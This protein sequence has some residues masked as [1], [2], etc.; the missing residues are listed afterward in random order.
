MKIFISWSGE[1]SHKIA[2]ILDQWIPCI[3][4]SVETFFSTE[5][6]EKGDNWD[7][8]ISERLSECNHGIICLTP[9]NLNAP[10]INFEA[11]AIAKTF[12]SKVTALMININPS[13]IKGPL[14]RYQATRLEKNDFYQLIFSINKELEKPLE[15][16]HLKN[17]FDSIW[18][19]LE[20][21]INNAI[22]DFS[23]KN[24]SVNNPVLN[25]NNPLE[26]ILQLL[27]I[28]NTMLSNPEKLIPIE[29]LQEHL[30]VEKKTFKS[31]AYLANKSKRMDDLISRYFAQIE[32]KL[33]ESAINFEILL[34]QL[35]FQFLFNIFVTY[36]L[37][38]DR[39]NLFERIEYFKA[40]FDKYLLNKQIF[41]SSKKNKAKPIYEETLEL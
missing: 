12:D 34:N 41:E 5:D 22:T 36:A 26:E 8:V 39:S 13:D 24:D 21:E 28:Q 16:K 38:Y 35:D 37:I 33:E 3:L 32:S 17:I 19:N 30:L 9:D 11:G 6:I 7:R 2:E 20:S 23:Q 29:Y 31:N 4:Q 25:K 14:S 18:K 10:W 27:R 15:D 40:K 1:L